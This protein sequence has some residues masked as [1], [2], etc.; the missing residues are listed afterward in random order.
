M[1]HSISKWRVLSLFMAVFSGKHL[2]YKEVELIRATHLKITSPR[3][4]FYQVDG[5]VDQCR[6][7]IV[8]KQITSIPI[9]GIQEKTLGHYSVK[10]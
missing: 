10:S 2:K 9:Q 4:I 5:E 8:T 3:F 1:I 7:C 6:T